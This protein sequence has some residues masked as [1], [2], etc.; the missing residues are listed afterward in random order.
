MHSAG[1]LNRNLVD[2]SA[3]K[4][5]EQ[6]E[7]QLVANVSRRTFDIEV[8]S[9]K[10]ESRAALARFFGVSRARVTQGLNR[11]KSGEKVSK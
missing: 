8:E 6:A 4:S 7:K 10:F 2:T 9:G 11:L 3:E 5:M 1:G